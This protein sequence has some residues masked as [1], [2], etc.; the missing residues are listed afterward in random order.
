MEV[1]E[2]YVVGSLGVGLQG[3]FDEEFHYELPKMLILADLVSD[4]ESAVIEAAE[5]VLEL[6]RLDKVFTIVGDVADGLR[7]GG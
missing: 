3:T 2:V 4:D 5:R 7:H 1:F 6:A